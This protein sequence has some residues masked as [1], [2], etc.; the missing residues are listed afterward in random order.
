[1]TLNNLGIA[2]AELPIGDHAEN[3]DQAI[4][5]YQKAL[6]VFAEDK[7]PVEWATTQNNL[8]TAYADFPIGDRAENLR[9]AKQCLL[10]ALK[11][12]KPDTFPNEYQT[13]TRNLEKVE[14]K[15]KALNAI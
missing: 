1:M 13:A 4:G 12:W 9:K 2:Y 11:L 7:F 15:L 6:Q 10:N 8:G 3:L 5:G 14:A